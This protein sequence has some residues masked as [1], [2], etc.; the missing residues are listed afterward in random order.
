[1]LSLVVCSYLFP[2]LSWLI[3]INTLGQVSAYCL[4]VPNP[5]SFPAILILQLDTT[6]ISPLPAGTVWRL[7][8]CR[9]LEEY[10]RKEGTVFL[11]PV[12]PEVTFLPA[13]RFLARGPGNDGD[14]LVHTL[15]WLSVAHHQATSQQVVFCSSAKAWG[16]QVNSSTIQ[17][18]S[19]I[20]S[21]TRSGCQPPAGGGKWT[22]SAKHFPSLD[23]LLQPQKWWLFPTPAIPVECL[24]TLFKINLL[25]LVN[26]S[27]C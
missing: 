7:C 10:C 20:P 24:L 19:A 23:A 6:N 5:P 4:C 17:G 12:L 9:V 14:L 2:Q 18:T 22:G 1:M 11:E 3:L 15:Q 21:L 26:N 16:T 27:L 8:Q 13:D 25:L